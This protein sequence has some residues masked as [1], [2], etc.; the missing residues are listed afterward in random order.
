MTN[1][2]T[3]NFL[4]FCR[5]SILFLSGLLFS[6]CTFE[7][8]PSFIISGTVTGLTGRGLILQNNGGDNVSVHVDG[9]SFTFATPITLGLTYNVSVF[10]H[11]SSPSQ[12]C[13]VINGQ[14]TVTSANITNVSVHCMTP[15]DENVGFEVQAFLK[16]PNAQ[17]GNYFGHSVAVSGDT[18]AVGSVG[19]DSNQTT[20]TNGVTASAD[21]SAIDAGAVY[22]F[23]RP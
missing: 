21:N 8:L 22:I 18:V 12:R 2:P 7:P 9:A 10:A 16:A 3:L 14:G 23:V 5:G 13:S 19:E 20:I 11:P 17:W 6:S 1:Q 4:L 15:L